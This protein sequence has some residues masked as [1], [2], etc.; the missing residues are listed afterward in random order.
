MTNKMKY[1][2]VI[3][4]LTNKFKQFQW[5][6]LSLKW[7]D[8]KLPNPNTMFVSI[9]NKKCKHQ[10]INNT[11]ND[12]LNNQNKKRFFLNFIYQRFDKPPKSE[13]Q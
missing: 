11:N 12:T 5:N 10:Q 9:E 7:H 1:S 4:T 6:Y 13:W 3:I 8:S 2:I